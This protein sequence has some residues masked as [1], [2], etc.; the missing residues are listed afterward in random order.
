[1]AGHAWTDLRAFSAAMPELGAL[2]REASVEMTRATGSPEISLASIGLTST[3]GAALFMT[4]AERG[5]VILPV[6]DRD[7]FLALVHG[8]K[9]DR[10]DKLDKDTTC[11]T[12][13]DVYACAS[14]PALLE[15]LGKGTVPAFSGN[16][17]GDIE[18]AARGLPLGDQKVALAAT[19]QLERG[20][21]AVRGDVMGLEPRLTAMLGAA[22]QPRLDGDRTTGFGI[23]HIKGL[24]AELPVPPEPIIQGVTAADLVRS[25]DDPIAM[26][27]KSNAIDLRVPLNDI[28]AAQALFV[29]H[30]IDGPLAKLSAKLVDG[31]CQLAAPGMPGVT[32]DLW[33]ADHALHI[34]QKNAAAGPAVELTPLGKELAGAP[35]QFAF[36]GRGS[37]L[38]LDPTLAAGMRQAQ[39]APDAAKVARAAI[40]GMMM[41]NELGVAVRLDGDTLRF[42]VGLRT[43]WSNPDDV[44]AS[45]VAINPDDILAGKG[46][47][48]AKPIV[49]A[50]KT[51]PLAGDVQAGSSGLVAPMAGVGILAAVAIPAFMDYMKKS[52]ASEAEL[53]LNKLGRSLKRIY[54]ETSQFP[55]GDAPLIPSGSTCCGRP[56]NA[57]PPDPAASAN[58]PVWTALDFALDGPTHYQYRY[59]SDGTTATV[60]AIGDLDCDGAPATYTLRVSIDP[61]THNPTAEL[62]PP[63]AGVY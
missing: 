30:C 24:L 10:T 32:I 40:R 33:I 51:A 45:L 11:A 29:D 2:L 59:H 47:E 14:D 58:D 13:H 20:A 48:L 21:I 62:T 37:V 43:A 63:V 56:E 28:T 6:G 27:M 39:L 41:L 17:R 36:Y 31:G 12:T 5:V 18:L 7:K 52:K 26:T 49:A 9:G 61:S 53:E 55:V 54:I 46:L 4:G 16:A 15:G 19:A 35:W 22:S 38:G 57:C 1:M 44:V 3:K 23:A 60:E 8:T 42:V 50:A 34:G 25:F